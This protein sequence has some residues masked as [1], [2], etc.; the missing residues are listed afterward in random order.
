MMKVELNGPTL[1]AVTSAQ[2]NKPE[3]SGENAVQA[4]E[5]DKVTLSTDTSSVAALTTQ[6]LNS[7]E[8]RQDRVDAL[9]QAIA[10]GDYKVDPGAIA[11]A[12]I[13]ESE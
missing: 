3:V 5:E 9:R 12:M 8:I 7:P 2:A 11:Q 1:D 4:P 13:G 10:S 6:A